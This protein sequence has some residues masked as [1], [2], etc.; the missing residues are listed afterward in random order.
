MGFNSAFKGLIISYS[1]NLHWVFILGVLLYGL[2]IEP[3]VFCQRSSYI[4]LTI[5]SGRTEIISLKYVNLL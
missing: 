2:T 4:F 1:K 5:F 3:S